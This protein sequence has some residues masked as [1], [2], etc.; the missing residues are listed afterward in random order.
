[1]AITL[2]Y[3]DLTDGDVKNEILV[4]TLAKDAAKDNLGFKIRA[5][6]KLTGQLVPNGITPFEAYQ[7]YLCTLNG[8]E[9]SQPLPLP[10][11]EAFLNNGAAYR[12]L[13]W[14]A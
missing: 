7:R 11:A 13:F 12:F 5:V 2:E 1:M 3:L 4:T 9:Y 14:L 6:E 10:L 8:L